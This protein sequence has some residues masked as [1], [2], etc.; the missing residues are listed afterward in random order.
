M[1]VGLKYIFSEMTRVGTK[2]GT[3][4]T[5][6]STC[7][8]HSTR[9]TIQFLWSTKFFVFLTWTMV[10][11]Q[12][13]ALKNHQPPLRVPPQKTRVVHLMHRKVRRIQRLHIKVKIFHYTQW[14]WAGQ[15]N[16]RCS[17]LSQR[18]Y[19]NTIMNKNPSNWNT[20][21]HWCIP[22]DWSNKNYWDFQSV[23]RSCSGKPSLLASQNISFDSWRDEVFLKFVLKP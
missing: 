17:W 7:S 11:K 19:M 23:F 12:M 14:T 10:K 3:K 9:K 5:G 20:A 6:H 15:T 1:K 8:I 16:L 2:M 18:P 4:L 13:K 22:A 21:M